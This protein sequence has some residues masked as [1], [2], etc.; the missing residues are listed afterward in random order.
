MTRSCSSRWSTAARWWCRAT[1][2]PVM[3]IHEYYA[4]KPHAWQAITWRPT[5]A[6]GELRGGGPGRPPAARRRS[7]SR[8]TTWSTCAWPPTPMPPVVLVA[9]IERGG[10]FAQLIGNLGAA[11]PGGCAPRV[12]RLRHQQVSRRRESLLDIRFA[13]VRPSAKPANRVLG[14]LPFDIRRRCSWMKKS[15]LGLNRPPRPPE[16]SE[17][18]VVRLPGH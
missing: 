14:V 2:R 8:R 17:V 1:R 12:A 7:I 18:A 9:D 15:S 3:S 6:G 4:Y 13:V 5:I 16:R 10:V 11:G